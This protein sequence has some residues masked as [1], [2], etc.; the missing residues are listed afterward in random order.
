MLA[1][2]Q[3]PSYP[4][5]PFQY[6][7]DGNAD[8]FIGLNDLLDLLSLYG[9][10][11][12]ESFY[13]DSTGA[14][15]F[16]GPKTPGGCLRAS[17]LAGPKWRIMTAFDAH[18]WDIVVANHFSVEWN[19]Q[20][21]SNF[22]YH[23]MDG[24]NDFGLGNFLFGTSPSNQLNLFEGGEGY[25][26]GLMNY[27]NYIPSSNDSNPVDVSLVQ[28]ILVTEVYPQIDYHIVNGTSEEVQSEVADSL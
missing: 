14:V 7:P 27:S 16:V 19:G 13:G 11:Y 15:L 23:L 9:Q 21:Y 25:P 18:K 28:C 6:N 4:E 22:G 26:N 24:D 5:Y 20:G 17:K 2:A 1:S 12:P 3:T 8:G 10:Q